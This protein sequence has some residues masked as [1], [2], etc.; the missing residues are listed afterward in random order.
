M[1]RRQIT[2]KNCMFIVKDSNTILEDTD[3]LIEDGRIIDVQRGLG[4]GEEIDCKKYIV[5]PG[6]V[7]SHVHAYSWFLKGISDSIKLESFFRKINEFSKET[8]QRVIYLSSKIAILEMLS[9]G[10]TAIMDTGIFPKEVLKA[11]KE[12]DIRAR[13]GPKVIKEE[14]IEYIE[15][16]IIDIKNN[17]DQNKI[18]P[19]IGIESISQLS[20]QSII[21]VFNISEKYHVDIHLS[22]SK[23]RKETFMIKKNTGLFPIE[24]LNKIDILNKK[25]IMVHLGWITSWELNMIKNNGLSIIY[26]PTYVMKQA[27]G[28]FFP[29]LEAIKAGL[30]IALGSDSVFGNDSFDIFHEMRMCVYLQRNNYWSTSFNGKDVFRMATIN[31]YN[32]LHERGGII[33]HGYL[34]DVVLLNGSAPNLRPLNKYN[35]LNNIVYSVSS[36]NVFATVIGGKIIYSDELIEKFSKTD[37]SVIEDFLKNI[38]V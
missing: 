2:L 38:L 37:L 15:S 10:I 26:C 17:S 20:E 11:I 19:I 8:L 4:G 14:D 33:D 7:N 27:T 16:E 30:N 6:L 24:Y 35:L 22:V 21:E 23:T 31:G 1:A 5:I 13:I 36:K 3:I 28:G 29:I 18:S 9:N 12:T 32:I 25:P 34:A